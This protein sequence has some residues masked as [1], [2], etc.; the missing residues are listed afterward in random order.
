MRQS[1]MF[2][3]VVGAVASG[4]LG[5]AALGATVT[6]PSFEVGAPVMGGPLNTDWRWDLHNFVTAENAITPAAGNRMLKFLATSSGGAGPGVACD[7]IQIVDMTA[8]ADQAIIT[9][10]F[11]SVTVGALFNRVGGPAPSFVD[12]YFGVNVRSHTSYA[13]AQSLTS[14]GLQ[15][16]IL[17]SDANTATWE[18]AVASLALPASTQYITI[19][20]VAAE[21]ILNDTS[22]VEFD[23]HYADDVRFALVPAPGS[24]VLA[25]L[26]G[27]V[28][29]RRR[30]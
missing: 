15:T 16:T 19:Q 2:G 21:D 3:A 5:G 6:N 26:G 9:T 18:S 28:L 14:T 10:G 23:G 25:G 22:G 20:L 17:F 8:P 30:R 27:L 4:V 11:G 29:A 12:T 13:N 24:V 7:V 1:M